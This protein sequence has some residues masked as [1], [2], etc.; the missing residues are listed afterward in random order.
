MKENHNK[1][2][3]KIQR[4]VWPYMVNK[5]KVKLNKSRMSLRKLSLIKSGKKK[6]RNEKKN[7]KKDNKEVSS[8]PTGN[9]ATDS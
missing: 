5:T 7:S 6:R 1:Q 8:T 9:K 4:T 3:K 2:I